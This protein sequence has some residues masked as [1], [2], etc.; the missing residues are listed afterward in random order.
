MR[1]G[2]VYITNHI[3]LVWG[4]TPSRWRL[5]LL[6]LWIP[7]LQFTKKS[8]SFFQSILEKGRNGERRQKVERKLTHNSK[9]QR[10]RVLAYLCTN[11][12]LEYSCRAGLIGHGATGPGIV[13]RHLQGRERYSL[14]KERRSLAIF[15]ENSYVLASLK[16]FYTLIMTWELPFTQINS[17]HTNFYMNDLDLRFSGKIS[18]RK[19]IRHRRSFATTVPYGVIKHPFFLSLLESYYWLRS[20]H[21]SHTLDLRS[22]SSLLQE[23]LHYKPKVQ[24]AQKTPIHA[25]NLW[26]VAIVKGSWSLGWEMHYHCY[27]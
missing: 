25:C 11:C 1:G 9:R 19:G 24:E 26:T 17:G 2:G 15:R 13:V 14:T 22:E 6:L 7:C 4:H 3:Q 21:I 12:S 5:L 8:I 10:G 18:A 20:N 16:H 23:H 27:A